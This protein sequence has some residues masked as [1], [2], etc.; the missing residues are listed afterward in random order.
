MPYLL[1]L[2][3]IVYII[4]GLLL[5]LISANAARTA[6]YLGLGALANISIITIVGILMVVMGYGFLSGMRWCFWLSIILLCLLILAEAM[7]VIEGQLVDLIELAVS[8]LV[9]Y[10][11]TRPNIKTWF[12]IAPGFAKRSIKH[13]RH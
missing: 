6:I 1:R 9:L 13:K 5:L 8:I 10:S 12:G 11:L 2:L 3:A 4:L 7:K